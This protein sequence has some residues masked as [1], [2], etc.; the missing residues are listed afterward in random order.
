MMRPR[1]DAPR[2]TILRALGL[3][4][5]LVAVPAL[6]ALA[7]A[8]PSHRRVL[9]APAA[10]SPVVG[11]LDGAITD[12]GHADFRHGVGR[13]PS[14]VGD[15]DVAVNLHGRGPESHRALLA[16]R[17]RRLVAFAHPDVPGGGEAEWVEDE[18]ESVRWCRLLSEHGIPAD[19]DDRYLD[20]EPAGRPYERAIVLHPGAASPARRWPVERWARLAHALA[21]RGRRVLV[22][23]TAAERQLAAAVAE[24]AGLGAD[25]VVA[26]RTS[27]GEL[28]AGIAAAD[29]LIS[30]DTG[31]AHLA[32]AVR[33]PSVL[34]F[35]PSS[36]A[37]WGPPDDGRHVVLWAGR[38]GDPHASEPDP[39]LLEIRAADVLEA[40]DVALRRRTGL[41]ASVSG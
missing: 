14:R 39:G 17:P 18:H 7:A 22:T 40:A 28:A 36:P 35:G 24:R 20:V 38:T 21:G 11:L 30:G 19:P 26:G 12:I 33:T 4:D 16:G 23:G 6:R 2:V 34:L 37:R 8:H 32:T 31:A 5:L 41:S 29:V 27:L 10:L 9:V 13:M 25:S 15:A 3:G 1:P